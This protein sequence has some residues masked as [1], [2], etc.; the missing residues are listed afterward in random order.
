MH[1]DLKA[2]PPAKRERLKTA[3]SRIALALFAIYCL[4]LSAA[5]IKSVLF[6][7]RGCCEC[8]KTWEQMTP[9]EQREYT[10]KV[11]RALGFEKSR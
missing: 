10:E 2:L 3:L 6:T 8:Q 5:F 11:E 9:E 4:L 1:D 7:A